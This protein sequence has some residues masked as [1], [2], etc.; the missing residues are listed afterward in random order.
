MVQWQ[1]LRN[2]N[3]ARATF[4]GG[5]KADPTHV[6]LWQA[7]GCMEAALVSVVWAWL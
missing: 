1:N 3:A 4:E 5:V 7:W 2:P 6:P